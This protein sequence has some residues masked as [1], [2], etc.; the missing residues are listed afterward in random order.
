MDSLGRLREVVRQRLV[1]EQLTEIVDQRGPL[2]VD[3]TLRPLG[4]RRD[5]WY[6][7]LVFTDHLDGPAPAP[8]ELAELLAAEQE[9]GSRDPYRRVAALLHLSYLR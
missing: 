8:D 9:A 5:C 7:V 3:D 4:W 6:G 2:S 1:A